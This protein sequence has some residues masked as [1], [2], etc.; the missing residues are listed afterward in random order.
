MTTP[1]FLLLGTQGCHLCDV[2]ADL[3]EQ[4]QTTA[5]IGYVD[6]AEA[7]NAEQLVKLYGEKIPLLLH[8]QTN[9][10]LF[11]PFEQDTLLAFIRSQS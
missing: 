6:I 10:A 11:W 5:A 4:S 1:D 3:I 8:I 9:Q 2:A 7:Q